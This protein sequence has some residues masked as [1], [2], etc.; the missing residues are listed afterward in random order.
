MATE[1]ERL[2]ADTGWLPEPLRLVS[3]AKAVAAVAQSGSRDDGATLPDFLTGDDEVL[4]A[5]D[6]DEESPLVAAE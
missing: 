3:E 5:D 4:T 2:L 1:A 6:K